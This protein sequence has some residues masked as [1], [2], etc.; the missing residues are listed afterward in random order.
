[1][2]ARVVYGHT[3]DSWSGV[4][5]SQVQRRRGPHR[6]HGVDPDGVFVWFAI[7]RIVGGQVKPAVIERG[8][9]PT[10]GSR[11]LARMVAL[12]AK[13]YVSLQGS[14]TTILWISTWMNPNVVVRLPP[15]HE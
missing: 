6:F 3:Y 5:F 10:P 8:R 11:A 2:L 9:G 14:V 13:Q 12:W 15:H 1:M 7:G 4:R